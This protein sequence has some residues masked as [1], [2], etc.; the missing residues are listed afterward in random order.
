[1]LGKLFWPE[2]QYPTS[3][4]FQPHHKLKLAR[5]ITEFIFLKYDCVWLHLSVTNPQQSYAKLKTAFPRGSNSTNHKWIDHFVWWNLRCV[6]SILW[7]LY[8]LKPCTGAPC[9]SCNTISICWMPRSCTINGFLFSVDSS[10]INILNQDF[11]CGNW[12]K[13]KIYSGMLMNYQLFGD[14]KLTKVQLN[15]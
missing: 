12:S 8:N 3:V 15:E 7:L 5:I 9:S 6:I 14:K 1:M 11:K 4:H 13:Y 10:I 2:I